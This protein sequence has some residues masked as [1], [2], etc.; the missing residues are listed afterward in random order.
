[1]IYDIMH[2]LTATVELYAQHCVDHF[3]PSLLWA[4]SEENP[5]SVRCADLN[6]WVYDGDT[7][8]KKYAYVP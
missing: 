1:M 5:M 7:F 3:K 2:A 8:M 4:V 6:L